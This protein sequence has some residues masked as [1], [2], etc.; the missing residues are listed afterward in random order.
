MSDITETSIALFFFSRGEQRKSLVSQL[1]RLRGDIWFYKINSVL[2]FNLNIVK[3]G[4]IFKF[5]F[6]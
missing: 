2:L 1:W 5:E 6:I 3:K 4:H